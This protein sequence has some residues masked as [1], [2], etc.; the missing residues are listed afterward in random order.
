LSTFVAQLFSRENGYVTGEKTVPK[1][2]R[3]LRAETGR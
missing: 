2:A 1:F 3:F